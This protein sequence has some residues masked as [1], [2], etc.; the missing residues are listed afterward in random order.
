M[1]YGMPGH[2][3]PHES[4]QSLVLPDSGRLQTLDASIMGSLIIPKSHKAPQEPVYCLFA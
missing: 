3:F 2:D 1:A 4:L